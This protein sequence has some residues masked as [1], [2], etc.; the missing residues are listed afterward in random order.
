VEAT[1]KQNLIDGKSS[2]YNL[3]SFQALRDQGKS[4]IVPSDQKFDQV[5]DVARDYGVHVEEL[6]PAQKDIQALCDAHV[7]KYCKDVGRPNDMKKGADIQKATNVVKAGEAFYIAPNR[8]AY[9]LEYPPKIGAKQE[10]PPQTQGDVK[11]VTAKQQ[12]ELLGGYIQKGRT[13][14]ITLRKNEQK[15]TTTPLSQKAKGL[16]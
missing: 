8:D 11:V 6:M 4:L 2:G 15:Q 14:E 7:K 1:R 3:E 10:I 13:E 12:K 16:R 9:I 5:R